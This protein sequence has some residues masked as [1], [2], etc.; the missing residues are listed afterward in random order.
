MALDLAKEIWDELKRHISTMDR[1][2]ATE[3]LVN[4]MID[5]GYDSTE[6]RD[7]FKGDSD[8]KRVLAAYMDDHDSDD[9]DQDPD[10]D[11]DE[12]EY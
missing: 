5:N 1:E 10:Q 2:E 3:S 8:V 6:I 11:P 4:V 12:D 7:A 9:I